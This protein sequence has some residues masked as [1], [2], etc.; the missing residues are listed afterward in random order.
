MVDSLLVLGMI[1]E[2]W[3]FFMPLGLSRV[4]KKW[5]VAVRA[6]NG[7]SEAPK[8]PSNLRLLV[9]VHLSVF[10]PAGTKD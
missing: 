10:L 2:T 6:E 7:K 9:F 1:L 3:I 5:R 4:C 8:K